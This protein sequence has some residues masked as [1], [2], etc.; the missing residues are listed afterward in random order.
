MS[1][2]LHLGHQPTDIAG[3]SGLL[4][5]TAGGFD[6]TLDINAIRHVG[7]YTYSAP[8]SI[9]VAAPLGDLWLGFRYVP[10]N[11]D[12][13]SISRSEASFLEF[14]DA[15]NVMIAQI[16]PV[17]S[18]N[19][20]H[21]IATGDTSVQGSS[22]YIAPNGQ[23]QWIDVRLSVGA[24]ITLELYV[25]GVLQTAATAANT[26][27]KGK[28]R[29]VLFANTALHSSVSTRT[30]YYA[31]IAVLDGV[32]TIGRRFV[33]RSPNAIA[34]FNQMVGSIDALKDS[35]IS[36][37]VASTAA[38]QRMS[39]SLTGPTG[40]ASV[41]AIAGL[42][43]KQIAQAGTDGPDAT[44]GFLRMGGVN[45]DAPPLTVPTLAPKALYSSWAVNPADASPWSNLTL[46]TE[47]GIVSA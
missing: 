3:I 31:H 21:A 1:Y 32:S 13:N 11:M 35:D 43:L 28:P 46:P 25:E 18:T 37:R 39:F 12:A 9:G 8:F 5:T 47:V 41:S 2:I 19:R 45:Y 30:W 29:H 36:T 10:P 23:P 14:Y 27:G 7:A 33:R 34:S 20:Y 40:P 24:A 17:T 42:H 26:G 4:S 6:A 44:A 15:A 38:G 22:S 16:K